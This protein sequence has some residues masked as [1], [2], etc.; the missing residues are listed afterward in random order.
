MDGIFSHVVIVDQNG[1]AMRDLGEG[2]DPRW[3][4]DGKR[5]LFLRK[6]STLQRG[7]E[8]WIENADGS[9]AKKII[10]D[11]SSD[12]QADWLP[13]GVGIVFASGR[14]GLS[15]V[16]TA[17]VVGGKVRK[18]G[19]QPSVN[20][21]HPQISPDGKTLV[22]ES[23]PQADVPVKRVSL[24]QIGLES[25]QAVLIGDGFHESI[26]WSEAGH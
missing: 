4:P 11:T 13:H 14:D 8:I 2:R 3:S 17:D 19:A 15:A 12:L 26:V 22:I 25:H 9:G 5:I 6:L 24:M 10:Q 18:L 16:F 7:T 20:W 21:F 23:V 1:D